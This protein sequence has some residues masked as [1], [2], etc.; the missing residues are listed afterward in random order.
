MNNRVVIITGST[1][2]IGKSI[3]QLLASEGALVVINGRTEQSV[4]EVV[5]DIKACGGKAIGV[6]GGVEHIETGERLVLEAVRHFGSV[7]V[8]I[9]NAGVVHDRM[10]H[11]MS[12]QEWDDVINSHLKGT[13]AS[14]QPFI[15]QVKKQQSGGHILNMTSTAGLEGTIG[16]LNYSAAKA[17]ILGMTWTLAKE[18]ARDKIVVNAIAPAALTDMTRPFVEAA[19]KK[20]NEQ[21]I[22]LEDYWN[23]GSADEVALFVRDLLQVQ[24]PTLT[25]QIFSVNG[26]KIGRWHPLRY[27]SFNFT[28][29]SI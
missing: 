25:G 12:E 28:G 15:K 22:E 14:T 23:I 2:G 17:G 27:E 1:K 21:G 13:F 4:E 29:F 5:A 8:L 26:K 3:A 16:Q 11:K 20:A 6:S 7:N 9:N 24:D 18:L 10:S 19:M